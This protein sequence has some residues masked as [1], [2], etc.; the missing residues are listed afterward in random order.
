M[1]GKVKYDAPMTEPPSGNNR[2]GKG[3]AIEL[4]SDEVQEILGTPPRWIIRWGITIMLLVVVI[5]ILGSYYYKYPDMISARITIL[6]ENP[7]V[8]IV[9]KS[10]GTLDRIFIDNN[11]QVASG[12]VQIGRASWRERV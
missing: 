3:G 9:A 10:N 8:Q 1:T 6:S 11:Q 2:E 5:L 12:E 4:R 7:P